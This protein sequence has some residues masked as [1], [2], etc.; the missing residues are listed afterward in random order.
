MSPVYYLDAEITPARSLSP[1]GLKTLLLLVA[2]SFLIAALVLSAVA[3]PGIR[4]FT[5]FMGLDLLG[6][7]FAFHVMNRRVSSE[8]VRVSSEVVEVFRSGKAVWSSAT[9]FT[10]VEP[11]ETAVRLA[12]SGRRVA[13]ARAL[14]PGERRDFAG[15]LDAAIRRALN[16]RYAGT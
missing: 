7:W 6:L 3:A 15:A 8:R 11:G 14:S 1:K 9:A 4:F 13:V 12:M 16:E 5:P 10:K 2:L